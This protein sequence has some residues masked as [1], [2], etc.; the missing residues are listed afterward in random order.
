MG[1]FVKKISEF[2]DQTADYR[3]VN[4]R[5]INASLQTR[6]SL[7]FIKSLSVYIWIQVLANDRDKPESPA[8]KATSEMFRW[9]YGPNNLFS[10]AEHVCGHRESFLWLH[11]SFKITKLQQL[12]SLIM[13]FKYAQNSLFIHAFM[14]DDVL[15]NL[16]LINEERLL[17]NASSHSKEK[18]FLKI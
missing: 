5:T 9:H 13:S 2:S 15:L 14:E 6:N 3:V 7:F 10:K 17:G 16:K 18:V 1:I 12:E 8:K 11:Q 4:F